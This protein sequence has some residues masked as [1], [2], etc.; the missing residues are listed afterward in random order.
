MESIGTITLGVGTD[1]ARTIELTDIVR[2]EFKD[3]R[4]VS[5]VRDEE[6][7]FLLSVENAGS[8]GRHPDSKMY[9]TEGSMIGILLT[10]HTF[11]Q[12]T[13]MNIEEKMKEY[14]I[15]ETEL[16]FEYNHR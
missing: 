7:G 4:L 9:L 6:N 2:C 3:H 5:V 15:G 14:S 1:E 16:A 10:L 12:K 11:L 8:T 13:G